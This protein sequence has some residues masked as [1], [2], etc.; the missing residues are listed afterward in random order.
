[1]GQNSIILGI[2]KLSKMLVFTNESYLNVSNKL[3]VACDTKKFKKLQ[4]EINFLRMEL[5]NRFP[6]Y[7]GLELFNEEKRSSIQIDLIPNE[8][9]LLKHYKLLILISNQLELIKQNLTASAEFKSIFSRLDI[10]CNKQLNLL[11][12]TFLSKERK[13]KK[14]L[15]LIA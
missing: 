9:I 5:G 12:L 15:M 13:V 3:K 7:C 1:M 4:K 2:V 11:R 6:W 8:S 14:E 10:I